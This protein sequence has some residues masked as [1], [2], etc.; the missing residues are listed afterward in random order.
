MTSSGRKHW[1][2]PPRSQ[3]LTCWQWARMDLLL[4]QPNR[5]L[6]S[7]WLAPGTQVS[8]FEPV[9]NS[10]QKHWPV[11]A[12]Q[13]PFE[14][15]ATWQW[16]GLHLKTHMESQKSALVN[17]SYDMSYLSITLWLNTA[18]FYQRIEKDAWT[19]QAHSK[20]IQK[21]SLSKCCSHL[22]PCEDFVVDTHR[23]MA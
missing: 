18:C 13:V 2:P 17:N 23:L 3:W 8:H 11:T 15:P 6:T 12:S 4:L 5:L 21:R 9:T 20:V 16:Q 14:A 7:K 1:G 22:D 10:L 19:T